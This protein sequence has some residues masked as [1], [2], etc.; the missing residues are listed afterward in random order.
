M[1][2]LRC[3]HLFHQNCVD[4][5]LRVNATCPTCRKSI[6]EEPS[7]EEVEAPPATASNAPATLNHAANAVFNPLGRENLNQM[8]IAPT[9]IE[10]RRETRDDAFGYNRL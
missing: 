7:T 9:P 3:T 10:S 8:P 5:W 2:Y 6:R 1:R 4:E